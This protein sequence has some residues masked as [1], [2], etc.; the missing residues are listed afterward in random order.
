[1]NAYLDALD[2]WV[3]RIVDEEIKRTG[4]KDTPKE[5]KR[6]A[7]KLMTRLKKGMVTDGGDD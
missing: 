4:K 2:R 7:A 1:M 6:I 5:R 3:T